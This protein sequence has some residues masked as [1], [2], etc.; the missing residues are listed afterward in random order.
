MSII[1]AERHYI[2]LRVTAIFLKHVDNK[3]RAD[4]SSADDLLNGRFVSGRL[5]KRVES[6]S[7]SWLIGYADY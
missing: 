5:I 7:L 6:V 4:G 3:V 2:S 1:D